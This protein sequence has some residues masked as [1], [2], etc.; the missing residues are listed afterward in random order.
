MDRID[1]RL[2][3]LVAWVL[4]HRFLA[5]FICLIIIICGPL[6]SANLHVDNSLNAYFV[7][8]DPA[9]QRYK[10]FRDEYDNDEFIYIVYSA[11]QGIFD[12]AT[13]KKTRELVGD[14]SEVPY[15]E[16]VK[17]VTNLEF[18]EGGSDDTLEI[19]GLMDDFPTSQAE[20]DRLERK[21]L[22]HPLYRRAYIS[23]DG[24]Y[25]AILCDVETSPE[26][27]ASYQS[28]IGASLA[29]VLA[30]PEYR[31]FEFWPT[32]QPV[33]V[34]AIN[35]VAVSEVILFTGVVAAIITALLFVFFR[36]A[37]AALA[38]QLCYLLGLVIVIATLSLNQFPIT[39]LS[40]VSFPV[41]YAIAVA[42]GIHVIQEYHTHLKA[43]NRNRESILK[44]VRLIG[45]ACLLTT[46]TTAVGFASVAI[47]PTPVIYQFGLSTAVGVLAVFLLCFTL[48]P[49]I[50]SFGGPRS[51]K[52]FSPER[53]LKTSNEE[54]IHDALDRF[55]AKVAD[56][57]I[58]YHRR[59]LR[60]AMLLGLISI[61]GAAQ[62]KTDAS[63]LHFFGDEI[64]VF[65]DYEFVDATMAGS[66]NFEILMDSRRAD[67]VRTVRFARTLE[68]I[69]DY[70]DSQE[71]LV[72]KTVSF[73]DII[74]EINQA[75]HDNDPSY[76]TLPVSDSELSQY[77]LL[78]EI[79]GGEELEKL[80]SGDIATA[81]LTILVKSTTT[82]ISKGFHDD[83]VA[84]AES[85]TPD[86][87]SFEVTG[88][89]YMELETLRDMNETMMRSIALALIIISI[90][91]IFVFRSVK[92][93]LV[94]LLPNV[95]PVIATMAIMGLVGIPLDFSKTVLACVA[96]G[97]A[98]DDTIHLFSRYR[99]EFEALGDYE[100]ALVASM[101]G[102]GHAIT[103]TTIILA[104]PLFA[105][106][107]S[108]FATM[109]NFGMLMSVC[110]II[111][112]LAD[113]FIAPSLILA[114]RPF[115]REFDRQLAKAR[116][117][118]CLGGDSVLSYPSTGAG[119]ATSGENGR[120]GA[121]R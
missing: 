111:A 8:G 13:L 81:R 40:M 56:W 62:I 44:T 51:E 17:S 20:A 36:Q 3:D 61:Y 101:R 23:E 84:F 35:D 92:V 14:L 22:Q 97:I 2:A 32:G 105:C 79:M 112:L 47:S 45:A 30:K 18:V 55:L 108:N 109:S 7:A 48:L 64:D 107:S 104:I 19:F 6:I 69:Q 46:L 74:K 34:S 63:W 71:Y 75:L 60:F 31:D 52:A 99:R 68:K 114:F 24:N 93:G 87:Y 89:S 73:V 113:Y 83:L 42:D 16:E 57:N 39:S 43:G 90:L 100:R 72:R 15:V 85:V 106:V 59:I 50:L 91:M 67:G 12:L 29:S 76:Y 117:P 53:Q 37:K 110:I 1:D 38:L 82:T 119:R 70:A 115:G 65:Q 10:T 11:R 98:V 28:E 26:G 95:F 96:I 94:S 103:R 49:V 41:L 9:Y 66:A 5:V 4:D 121:R 120:A 25:A 80:V 77:L 27:G 78:Y 54:R 118:S 58:R 88:L 86:D 102:V 21:L 33:I 116:F